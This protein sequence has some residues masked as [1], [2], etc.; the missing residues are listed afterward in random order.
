MLRIQCRAV[1]SGILSSAA[2]SGGVRA[3][4]MGT[5]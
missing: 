5:S 3:W 4:V 1:R 2:I